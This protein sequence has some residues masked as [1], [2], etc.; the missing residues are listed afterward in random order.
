MI[1]TAV[2]CENV[3]DSLPSIFHYPG[4]APGRPDRMGSNVNTSFLGVLG[5]HVY[6]YPPRLSL[7]PS[8]TYEHTHKC[9]HSL[10][11]GWRI[12]KQNVEPT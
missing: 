12:R 8:L 5:A 7:N 3:G 2:F 9:T 11:E 6:S 1:H 10:T 4:S